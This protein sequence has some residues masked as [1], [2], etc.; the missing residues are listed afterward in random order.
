MIFLDQSVVIPDDMAIRGS[1]K[2]VLANGTLHLK[3][4]LIHPKVKRKPIGDPAPL[5]HLGQ[6]PELLLHIDQAILRY[7]D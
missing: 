6:R 4:I 1:E 5:E 2:L 7:S 3:P